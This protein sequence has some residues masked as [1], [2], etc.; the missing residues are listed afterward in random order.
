MKKRILLVLLILLL[1][2]GGVGWVVFGE[3]FR[4]SESGLVLHG[5]VD[6]RQLN[7]SFQIAERI[8]SIKVDE[9]ALVKKGEKL[10]ELETVR[11]RNNLD[12]AQAACDA[13]KANLE[14]L[15]NGSRKED[16]EIA[17]AAHEAAKARLSADESDFRRQKALE[18]TASVSAQVAEKAEAAYLLSKAA[19]SASQSNLEKLR[20]GSRKED[21]ALAQAQ[22]SQTAAQL[23]IH[24]Q[25]LRDAVLY[26]PCDGVVRSRLLHP[27]EMTSPQSPVLTLAIISPKWVRIYLPE[28]ML[29]RIRPG[30]KARIGLDSLG[31]KTLEG[32]VGF[33]SPTA[34]FTPKNIETPELRTSLVYEV[35][36]MVDDPDN[37]LKLGA[38]A[39][40]T[41]PGPAAK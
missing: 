9:G 30:D 24:Q 15:V 10:A 41:F 12:A 35:R 4:V 33:I 8:E 6:D 18:K 34:E 21:I 23:A 36:V 20:N 11:L 38:P 2:A 19:V 3:R 29:T 16:I 25:A 28:T 5:N 32:W 17:E 37:F 26:A 7:L 13:A 40:V 1:I 27:G 22:L 31:D 39:T 14:K